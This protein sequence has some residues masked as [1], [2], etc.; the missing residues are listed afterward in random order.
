MVYLMIVIYVV[1]ILYSFYKRKN[2]TITL[3][4]TMAPYASISFINNVFMT[5][6]EYFEISNDIIRCILLSIVPIYVGAFIS[7]VIGET[8]Y[9]NWINTIDETELDDKIAQSIRIICIWY[10]FCCII[11][12]FQIFLLYRSY[13]IAHIAESD[14]SEFGLTGLPSH[15]FL[16]TYPLGAMLF[17]YGLKNK[18]L[19]HIV[20]FFLGAA[21]AT[22]SFIKY[23]AII[24]VL[25]TFIYCIIKDRKQVKKLAFIFG[26]L[27]VVIFIGN[28]AVGFMLRGI[29]KYGITDYL[30]KLWDYVGGSLINSNYSITEYGKADYKW[31]DVLYS[32]VI[33]IINMFYTK[34][35]GTPLLRKTLPLGFRVLNK[36]GST[37]NVMSLVFVNLY[38]GSWIY[39]VIYLVIEGAIIETIMR[40]IR[41]RR[42]D[43]SLPFYVMFVSVN[44][45]TFFANYYELPAVW[46]I[47]IWSYVIPKLL[48]PKKKIKIRLGRISI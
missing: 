22:L 39:F 16:T 15:M 19:K 7:K 10:V 25:Y 40:K 1:I 12:L 41:T 20:L 33:P 47:C 36:Y 30:R 46:E 14:F 44:L 9:S 45:L 23:H 24:F 32:S 28:Y 34:L 48:L 5:K 37:S 18:S 31:Y 29:T 4:F 43:N 17:Y 6:Y 13:G 2:W 11:R 42:N 27:I 8:N 3:L 21:V 38:T 35:T 26:G